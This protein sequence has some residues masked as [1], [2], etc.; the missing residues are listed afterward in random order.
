[1]KTSKRICKNGSV[2][3]KPAAP[4]CHFCGSVE[5]VIVAD[6]VVI[7]NDCAKKLF[8]KVDKTDD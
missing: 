2:T 8:A 4:C 7:C 3:I 5:N 6:N 1:M